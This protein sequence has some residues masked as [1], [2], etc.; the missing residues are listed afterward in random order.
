EGTQVASVSLVIV[1]P[2]VLIVGLVLMFGSGKLASLNKY[3]PRFV[4]NRLASS[5]VNH[6]PGLESQASVWARPAPAG[7]TLRLVLVAFSLGL[8]GV[9]VVAG[10]AVSSPAGG[11]PGTPGGL[12]VTEVGLA[13]ILAAYGVPGTRTAVPI[14]VFRVISYWVPAALGFLAGGTTFLKS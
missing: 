13:L 2:I 11:L 12:G 6:A 14:I 7:A 9:Q 5:V 4:R 1:A 8:S 10:F 3:L